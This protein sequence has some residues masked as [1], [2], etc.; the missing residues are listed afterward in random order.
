MIF[1]LLVLLLLGFPFWA[2]AEKCGPII[3]YSEFADPSAAGRIIKGY[4]D[5][6][7]TIG[8]RITGGDGDVTP[9]FDSD[10]PPLVDTRSSARN[11]SPGNSPGNSSPGNSSPS[12]TASNNN[13]QQGQQGDPNKQD[14]QAGAGGGGMPGAGGQ[15]N[16]M[17][18]ELDEYGRD[19]EG[20]TKIAGGVDDS[21][22][23]NIRQAGAQD[24]SKRANQVNALSKYGKG[25]KKIDLDFNGSNPRQTFNHPGLK[26]SPVGVRSGGAGGRGRGLQGGSGGGGGK[27]KARRGG[28]GRMAA[29]SI[30]APGGSGKAK[31][32]G[33]KGAG[34]SLRVASLGD[35]DDDGKKGKKD[36]K[37]K[38]SLKKYLPKKRL[39]AGMVGPDGITGKFG[40]SLFEKVSNRYGLYYNK[41]LP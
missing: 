23:M 39:P 19:S 21:E 22:K 14:Q 25:G 11:S 6:V 35:D 1:S 4:R 34:S 12:N 30:K 31:G 41:L 27:G 8:T 17:M 26:V 13:G 38:F 5:S 20:E 40:P 28:R 29:S 3:C 7:E 36:F 33:R 10:P 15:G 37:S 18:P 2:S 32:A 24:N 9:L 16:E